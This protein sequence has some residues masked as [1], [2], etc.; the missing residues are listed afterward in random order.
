MREQWQPLY[1]DTHLYQFTPVTLRKMIEMAELQITSERRLGGD[2]GWGYH[3]D[4]K[5][6]TSDPAIALR[7]QSSPIRRLK[8][9]IWHLRRIV[10]KVHFMHQFIRYVYWHLMGNGEYIRMTAKKSNQFK[11]SDRPHC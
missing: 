11:N 4:K 8:R 10:F 2:S 9:V 7:T 6:D 3:D 1:P 5:T